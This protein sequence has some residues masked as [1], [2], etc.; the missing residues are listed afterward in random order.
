VHSN[1][2][3][4]GEQSERVG[5]QNAQSKKNPEKAVWAGD[6]WRAKKLALYALER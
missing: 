6:D 4:T 3:G 5:V 1:A 2:I